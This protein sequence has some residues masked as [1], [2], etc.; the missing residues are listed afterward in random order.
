MLRTSEEMIPI[1]PRSTGSVSTKID[2]F[3]KKSSPEKRA[4][5]PGMAAFGT[6]RR[7]PSPGWMGM[8]PLTPISNKMS[9]RINDS[10][11]SRP[12][13]G[14][15]SSS[16]GPP[17]PGGPSPGGTNGNKMQ[18]KP[19]PDGGGKRRAP[20]PGG[21]NVMRSP[22]LSENIE[23]QRF[24]FSSE[25]TGITPTNIQVSSQ[26]PLHVSDNK[27]TNHNFDNEQ[28]QSDGALGPQSLGGKNNNPLRNNPDFMQKISEAFDSDEENTN[29]P[30]K[31]SKKNSNISK[32]NVDSDDETID[33]P[34]T[35]NESDKFAQPAKHWVK[36]KPISNN[37]SKQRDTKSSDALVRNY[38][39][40]APIPVRAAPLQ[41]AP[42]PLSDASVSS[43]TSRLGPG[44][45]AVIN[46]LKESRGRKTKQSDSPKSTKSRSKSKTDSPS[47][48]SSNTSPRKIIRPSPIRAS[49]PLFIPIRRN[50]GDDSSV[51]SYSTK[52][53]SSVVY[54]KGGKDDKHGETLSQKMRRASSRSPMRRHYEE[55]IKNSFDKVKPDEHMSVKKGISLIQSYNNAAKKVEGFERKKKQM[56]EVQKQ[57]S[58][59]SKQ[60]ISGVNS[61][62]ARLK[63]LKEKQRLREEEKQ[64]R[65]E[66]NKGGNSKYRYI[67]R[68]E[69]K[70][71]TVADD[72]FTV[73]A[74]VLSIGDES[75]STSSSDHELDE[76]VTGKSGHI[77]FNHNSKN[78]SRWAK[79]MQNRM[80]EV[81]VEEESSFEDEFK[82]YDNWETSSPQRSLKQIND[83]NFKNKSPNSRSQSQHID[84]SPIKSIPDIDTSESEIVIDDI[85]HERTLNEFQY[86]PE[87]MQQQ[88]QPQQEIEPTFDIPPIKQVTVKKKKEREAV[89]LQ[90]PL[91]KNMK[92]QLEAAPVTIQKPIL[93]SV[94]TSFPVET[95]QST[96]MYQIPITDY[97]EQNP[98]LDINPYIG[99]YAN[100]LPRSTNPLIVRTSL[101]TVSSSLTNLSTGPTPQPITPQ[102]NPIHSSYPQDVQVL[103]QTNILPASEILQQLTYANNI[104]PR[105]MSQH[106][107]YA[108]PIA[109]PMNP[110]PQNSINGFSSTQSSENPQKMK[111][112]YGGGGKS[113]DEFALSN[114]TPDSDKTNAN[115]STNL[116]KEESSTLLGQEHVP[117]MDSEGNWWENAANQDQDVSD[118]I[119]ATLLQQ[120]KESEEEAKPKQSSKITSSTKKTASQKSEMKQ[121]KKSFSLDADS[122][123]DVFYGLESPRDQ[124]SR[125]RLMKAASDNELDTILSEKVEEEDGKQG[126]FNDVTVSSGDSAPRTKM[127]KRNL[128]NNERSDKRPS[129]GRVSSKVM[130][131]VSSRSASSSG[132]FDKFT[133]GV[134]D[135]MDSPASHRRG[136]LNNAC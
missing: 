69:E 37:E 119:K 47:K 99:A 115:K 29:E 112:N 97:S 120:I 17:S 63:A 38:Q 39:Q 70:K 100:L 72:E 2:M 23:P 7:P 116:S 54:G 64:Q 91:N 128:N 32:P 40:P 25:A 73:D 5:S 14:G 92:S 104:A 125:K 77:Q 52:S 105:V 44:K 136:M 134:L 9:P 111:A 117:S 124:D 42:V 57:K 49:G 48:S 21:M 123:D 58:K 1:P 80:A 56:E 82:S 96:L 90:A 45:R 43:M 113:L 94:D 53:F 55:G 108:N 68:K 76:N 28:Q 84:L 67:Q 81:A 10:P 16:K 51:S 3:E 135:P 102:Q 36:L 129:V 33:I 41:P 106:G 121:K 89:P 132:I 20:S 109:T 65:L 61:N 30:S 126:D 79:I 85:T 122:D 130:G 34:A 127:Q 118:A 4:P 83:Q 98:T 95:N 133:C 46:K 88:K 8:G 78:N 13:P 59:Q 6:Q 110:N 66:E 107:T 60:S 11:R 131:R 74:E 27:M 15:V 75:K 93:N 31:E 24:V 26:S 62:L 35:I 71:P 103:P 18:K 87:N 101:P 86:Q 19:R 50:N 22:R 114:S 12:M